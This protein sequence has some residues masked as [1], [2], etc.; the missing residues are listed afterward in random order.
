MLISEVPLYSLSSNRCALTAI[1]QPQNV[2]PIDN[3]KLNKLGD[4]MELI[5]AALVDFRKD[6]RYPDFQSSSSPSFIGPR[7]GI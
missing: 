4:D 7:L 1:R 5:L 6:L 3:A 2:Q